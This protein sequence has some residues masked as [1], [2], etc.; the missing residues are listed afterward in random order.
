MK[1]IAV[2]FYSFLIIF[3]FKYNAKAIGVVGEGVN[4]LGITRSTVD[5]TNWLPGWNDGK[6]P[7]ITYGIRISFVKSNGQNLKSIDYMLNLAP[8]VKMGDLYVGGYSKAHYINGY[9]KINFTKQSLTIN[10]GLSS[11]K[12]IASKYNF[13]INESYLSATSNKKSYIYA[14]DVSSASKWFS[15]EMYNGNNYD[16]DLKKF[17][18]EFLPN[19]D[20][21][22][23]KS[24]SNLFLIIEPTTV[25]NFQGLSQPGFY[26][27]TA[28]ELTLLASIASETYSTSLYG[29]TAL[30]AFYDLLGRNLPCSS[31]VTGTLVDKIV[32]NNIYNTSNGQELRGNF[33][34]SNP[35]IYFKSIRSNSA[36]MNTKA[37]LSKDILLGDNGIGMAVVWFFDQ[38]TNEL[39][40]CDTIKKQVNIPSNYTVETSN[41]ELNV[42]VNNYNKW[43][44][45]NN[46]N[47]ITLN[48]LKTCLPSI[49]GINCKP[50]YNVGTCLDSD[51]SISVEYNDINGD[52]NDIEYWNNC[53]FN[54][55]GSYGDLS[56]HKTAAN[57]GLTYYESNLGGKYCEVYCVEELNASFDKSLVSIKAGTNFVWGSTSQVNGTR[58]CKTK[59]V[60][61]SKFKSDINQINNEIKQKYKEWQLEIL[62]QDAIK[63]A[64]VSGT[65]QDNCVPTESK[66][67]TC[68]TNCVGDA[69]S[70]NTFIDNNDC[71]TRSIEN[72]CS[73]PI[74]TFRTHVVREG[75]EYDVMDGICEG[76]TCSDTSSIP[77]YKTSTVKYKLSG[78]KDKDAITWTGE[79]CGNS[80]PIVNVAKA[81]SAYEEAVKTANA[82]VL[83]MKKCYTWNAS[84]IYNMTANV[85]INYSDPMYPYAGD[86]LTSVSY[87]SVYK[88]LEGQDTTT[89][90]ILNCNNN[91]CSN[92]KQDVE[93]YK[94]VTMSRSGIQTFAIDNSIYRYVSKGDHI[95]TSLSGVN[96][97][98][99]IDIG[100]GNLP[101]SYN[102]PT[103]EYDISLNYYNL[104][105]ISNTTKTAIDQVLESIPDISDGKEMSDN[106]HE[107]LCKYSVDSELIC[108]PSDKACSG[109]L[110][111]LYRP[112]DL[113]NPFPDINANG[114]KTGFNWCDG[115]DC[116]NTNKI[117]QEVITNKI[118]IT[119]KKPMY[120]FVLT[121]N[122]IK[123]IR[124]YNRKN[125]YDDFNL[126]CEKSTGKNCISDFVTAYIKGDSITNNGATANLGTSTLPTGT[127]T[128]NRDSVN[129]FFD[130]CRADQK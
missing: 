113:K 84:D 102:T 83:E 62:K 9:S 111:V 42:I 81:K 38:P 112:I 1:K 28:Y 104:G 118:H 35:S 129:G 128:Y 12:N 86:L 57:N 21:E 130:K 23:D 29:K 14:Y 114:R 41:Q 50:S 32:K 58:T 107:W 47:E 65:C 97:N 89:I 52:I 72:G 39:S 80:S 66:S 94:S 63:T 99:Y 49:S 124:S 36:C 88:N 91:K 61:I 8:N 25:V 37:N 116:S 71:T 34:L 108:D 79:W 56:V 110:K 20:V 60:N 22:S 78:E 45:K 98:K 75:Y 5:V 26:Y 40:T 30:S 74:L 96:L 87:G 15:K 92:V 31:Y 95:S 106:Y 4:G 55:K 27:G 73:N 109:G 123:Q 122:I 46:Y 43:A 18:H 121:P 19:Y 125:P 70:N 126:V 17:L 7:N 105:H 115:T 68:V 24:L 54:D 90:N 53:I 33:K 103:G 101:V 44:V 64:S 100:Y 76:N 69:C 59:D 85:S 10:Q 2:I 119:S 48:Y 120:S 82:I 77:K 67:F 117:V 6:N 93:I 127:C 16:D 3:G 13:V 51:K 11:F